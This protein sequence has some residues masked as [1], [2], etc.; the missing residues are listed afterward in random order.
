MKTQIVR[1]GNSK[2][3]RIPKAILEEC[4][5]G[6]E[7]ELEVHPDH[8]TVKSLSRPRAGWEETFKKTVTRKEEGEKGWPPSTWDKEEWSW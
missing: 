3:I 6:K 2:G 4:H 5:L 7:V 1:I 8:L